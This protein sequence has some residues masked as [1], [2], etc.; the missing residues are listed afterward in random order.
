MAVR[1]DRARKIVG[2]SGMPRPAYSRYP[3]YPAEVR[4]RLP[5]QWRLP[6]SAQPPQVQ[7]PSGSDRQTTLDRGW[8]PSATR[9]CNAD[10]PHPGNM[11]RPNDSVLPAYRSLSATAFWNSSR[12]SAPR[13]RT[14]RR[15]PTWS[16]NSADCGANS[17]AL[18]KASRAPNAS[19]LAIR[20]LPSV[21]LCCNSSGFCAKLITAVNREI[22]QASFI[23]ARGPTGQYNC[24]MTQRSS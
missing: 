18:R 6:H 16:C 14:A 17:L 3:R 7:F 19:P 15:N 11:R 22:Q 8:R 21:I 24:R 5:T 12:A 20:A 10:N 9:E 13:L 23:P 4:W 1:I 2:L